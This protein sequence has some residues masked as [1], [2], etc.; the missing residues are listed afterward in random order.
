MFD[1]RAVII[2]PHYRRAA[3]LIGAAENNRR[4]NCSVNH[5]Q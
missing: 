3:T 4:H 2:R 5:P 1:L